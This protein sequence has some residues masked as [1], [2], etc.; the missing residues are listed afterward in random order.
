M[1]TMNAGARYDPEADCPRWLRFL[2]EVFD[3]DAELIDFVQRAVGYSLTG[4]MSACATWSRQYGDG[5]GNDSHRKVLHTS[6][7]GF[8]V[9]G[10]TYA[11]G[12]TKGDALLYKLDGLGNFVWQR[13]YGGGDYEEFQAAAQASDGGYGVVD[14]YEVG[15]YMRDSLITPIYEGTSQIQ[16]MVIAREI[17][18]ELDS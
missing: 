6:D 7:G 18:E 10:V 2:D 9:A 12:A 14:E 4:D 1:I 3:G 11:Y 15:R 5:I 8:L 13:L 17:L 16:R